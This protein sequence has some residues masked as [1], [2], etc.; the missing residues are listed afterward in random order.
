[1]LALLLIRRPHAQVHSALLLV[2]ACQAQERSTGT[3]SPSGALGAGTWVDLS[4]DFSAETVYWPTATPF[5]FKVM[6]AER[7]P[8]GYY[9]ASDDFA[10][11]QH[12]GT[13]ASRTNPSC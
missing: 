8:A 9:Y 5:W 10:A 4:H 3:D 7:T 6:S 1:M 12:G 11:S 2:L 13:A